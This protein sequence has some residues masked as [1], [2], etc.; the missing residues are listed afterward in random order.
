MGRFIKEFIK[1]GGLFILLAMVISACTKYVEH[2]TQPTNIPATSL[3]NPTVTAE[4]VATEVTA[5][6]TSPITKQEII[7]MWDSVDNFTSV[8]NRL[9]G[10]TADEKRTLITY[11][12]QEI[13]LNDELQKNCSASLTT[14]ERAALKGDMESPLYQQA[15]AK[16]NDAIIND[17]ACS[18]SSQDLQ[19]LMSQNSDLLLKVK[20]LLSP[21]M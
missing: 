6:S 16:F 14:E 3:S 19:N 20:M 13:K 10:L 5:T 1:I 12:S 8:I 17:P 2:E 9:D 21:Y 4:A 15:N 7:V 11:I 18:K